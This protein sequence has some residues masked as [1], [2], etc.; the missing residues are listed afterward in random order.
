MTKRHALIMGGLMV[1]AALAASALTASITSRR[2]RAQLLDH[3]NRIAESWEIRYDSLTGAFEERGRT[4]EGEKELRRRLERTNAELAEEL[5]RQE[6]EITNLTTTV[7]RLSV[8]GEVSGTTVPTTELDPAG[9][10]GVRLSPSTTL[11]YERS[12]V[13][14]SGELVAYPDGGYFGDLTVEADLWLQT[15][16]ARSPSGELLV[17]AESDIPTLTFTEVDVINNLNDPLTKKPGL[18]GQ[19]FDA[20][21]LI[22]GLGAF[23][24]GSLV[25]N[26]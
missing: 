15:T 10:G 24:A 9:E 12:R 5:D 25:G 23:I 22:V 20:G 26:L 14:L 17:Y 7:A 8:G 13:H 19:V 3:G 18:F 6:A 16:V 4:V 21:T 1:G 2:H 11:Q